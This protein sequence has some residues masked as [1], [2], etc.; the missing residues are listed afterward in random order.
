MAINNEYLKNVYAGLCQRNPGE[1]EFLQVSKFTI[2][3]HFNA[4][5]NK[6]KLCR[7]KVPMERKSLLCP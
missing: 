3:K 2:A 6:S 5:Y 4:L 7:R 1:K